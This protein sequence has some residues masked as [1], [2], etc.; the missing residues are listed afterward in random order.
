[1]QAL[2]PRMHREAANAVLELVKKINATAPMQA[3]CMP[4]QPT[5]T[6]YLGAQ[7]R[8]VRLAPNLNIMHLQQPGPVQWLCLLSFLG[9]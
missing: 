4:A 8:C 9:A 2:E 3:D 5:K 1:M 7:V 6:V